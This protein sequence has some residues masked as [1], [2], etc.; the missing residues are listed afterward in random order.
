MTNNLPPPESWTNKEVTPPWYKRKRFAIPIGVFAFLLILGILSPEEDEKQPKESQKEEGVKSKP[1]Q[2]TEE[3][4]I[5]TSTIK[6]PEFDLAN[7]SNSIESSF[8]EAYGAEDWDSICQSTK[9]S[10]GIAEATYEYWHCSFDRIEAR[11]PSWITIYLDQP[12]GISDDERKDIAKQA[13]THFYNFIG[14]DFTE[15]DTI[16]VWVGDLD[17]ATV[18]RRDIYILNKDN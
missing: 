1:V 17:S 14:E 8:L 9:E 2:T 7:Y 3:Q 18:Y 13:G 15:L 16:V 4:R 12:G 11:S 6:E 5:T 10:Y